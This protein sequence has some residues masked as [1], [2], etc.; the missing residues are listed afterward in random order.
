MHDAGIDVYVTAVTFVTPA[1]C[2]SPDNHYQQLAAAASTVAQCQLSSF[3]MQLT[4]NFPNVMFCQEFAIPHH[5]MMW[6][7]HD[8]ALITMTHDPAHPAHLACALQ[9]HAG[10]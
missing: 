7:P 6:S 10:A 8:I 2:L 1:H 3:H 4:E 5:P 9:H